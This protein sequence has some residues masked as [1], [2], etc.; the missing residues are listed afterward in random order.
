MSTY[1]LPCLRRSDQASTGELW[2]T[3]ASQHAPVLAACPLCARR[4]YP[5]S[6]GGAGAKWSICSGSPGAIGT[7]SVSCKQHSAAFLVHLIKL[8]GWPPLQMS[9]GSR[10]RRAYGCGARLGKQCLPMYLLTCMVTN[11]HRCPCSW[12]TLLR[13][14]G[15]R[16]IAHLLWSAWAS[17]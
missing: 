14:W 7:P 15:R 11:A 6:L 8:A 13:G 4:S 17:Y 5:S 2:F 12:S 1:I 9:C 10:Y 16:C 3:E